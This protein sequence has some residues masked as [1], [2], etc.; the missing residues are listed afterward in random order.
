MGKCLKYCIEQHKYDEFECRSVGGLSLGFI[1]VIN[2]VSFKIVIV[3]EET[4]VGYRLTETEAF[5]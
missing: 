4:G 3:F 5:E 1:F 2:I